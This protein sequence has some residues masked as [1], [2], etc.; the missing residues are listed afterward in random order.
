LPSLG[1]TSV[2]HSLRSHRRLARRPAGLGLLTG[3]HRISLGTT[4]PPRFLGDPRK[5]A[6]L[7]WLRRDLRARPFG[8][9]VLPPLQHTASAPATV[10]SKLDHA[11]RFLPV[12]ASQPRSPSVH[13]TLGSGWWPALP[14]QVR[15][16]GSRREVSAVHLTPPRPGFAWRTCRSI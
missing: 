8:T 10:L 12:Y 6:A 4:G 11:A 2:R 14:G 3:A 15:P 13:A 7:L 1:G 16:A 9:S 5:R